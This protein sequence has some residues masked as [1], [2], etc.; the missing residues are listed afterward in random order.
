M[1]LGRLIQ[2]APTRTQ[3]PGRT[4]RQKLCLAHRRGSLWTGSTL[5]G[6][7]REGP[8]WGLRRT[9]SG[10]WKETA[11]VSGWVF[12]L[13]IPPTHAKNRLDF[14]H[15]GICTAWGP[16]WRNF[17]AVCCQCAGKAVA[18]QILTKIFHFSSDE[19]PSTVFKQITFNWQPLLYL[20]FLGLIKPI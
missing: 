20:S 1:F 17:A 5:G 6:G 14:P 13:E 10:R 9:P 7:S 8:A 16:T 12:C 19:I 4:P 3:R 11:W 18:T 2:I 15:W